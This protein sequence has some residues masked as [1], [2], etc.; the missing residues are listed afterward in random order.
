MKIGI[1][2]TGYV[3]LMTGTGL[4]EIGHSVVC[5]DVDSMRI[6]QIQNGVSPIH[7]P[8]LSESLQRSLKQGNISFT[9]TPKDVVGNCQVL[10]I[11]VGT[12]SKTDGSA[13]LSYVD[14][15]AT[16]I[17]SLMTQE[18]TIVVKST[19][20]VGTARRI[21]S[22]IQSV[23]DSRSVEIPFT[24]V[25]NPEF[26]KEGAGLNDFHNP[27]RIIVGVNDATSLA[28]MRKLYEPLSREHEKL[29]VMSCESA[30]L[31]KYAANAMLATRISFMNEIARLSENLGA[32]IQ[33][34]RRGI[35]TDPRIGPDFLQAG[36]G[37]G[38]SC[39]S[40]DLASLSSM[41]NDVGVTTPLI[42]A[43]QLVNHRQRELLA[44]KA[45]SHFGS[46]EGLTCAVWGLSFKPNTNDVR[47][48]PS[49]DLIGDLIRGGASVRA[50]DPV[51]KSLEN[52]ENLDGFSICETRNDALRDADVLFLVTEWNEF[53]SLDHDYMGSVMKQKV[54]IDGRNIWDPQVCRSFGFHY[55]GIGRP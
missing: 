12:P 43:V 41:A 40:K 52:S 17:G 44:Q 18:R 36:A 37:F 13:N 29:V 23:L 55:F 20:P 46:L 15:V 38:G 8:G 2:G 47:D 3:G 19:V 16:T 32:D 42:D 10:F 31:A 48:S 25:S 5:V 54:V 51:V 39:F 27:D 45:H 30:E 6:K 11:A 14:E 24:V 22:I 28:I 34:I 4:A 35:G 9:S 50:Y 21:S 26:L 7:D 49:L 53:K 33:D 1:F